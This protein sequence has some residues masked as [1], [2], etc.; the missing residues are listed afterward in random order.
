MRHRNRPFV[1][2]SGKHPILQ[3]KGHSTP[4]I[5]GV[6]YQEPFVVVELKYLSRR[7]RFDPIAQQDGFRQA[8][9]QHELL[10]KLFVD[11]QGSKLPM[12]ANPTKQFLK[13][14]SPFVGWLSNKNSTR[15]RLYWLNN[16][17]LITMELLSFVKGLIP[18]NNLKC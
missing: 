3:I 2:S 7:R 10:K 14:N 15:R 5:L 12:Q 8:N 17:L 4:G 1:A 9:G 13:Q 16:S 11:H 18:L 6:P